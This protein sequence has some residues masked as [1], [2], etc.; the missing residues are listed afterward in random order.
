MVKS[1]HLQAYDSLGQHI[2]T[3]DGEY[4]YDFSGNM[5]LRVDG[6]EAYDLKVP[7]SYVG[8]FSGNSIRN[9]SGQCIF[10]FAE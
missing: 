2:G 6:D 7:C 8:T 10:T 9:L 4:L 5:L 3:F 1:V